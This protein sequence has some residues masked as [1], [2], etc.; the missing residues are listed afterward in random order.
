MKKLFAFVI[1]FMVGCTDAEIASITALGEEA[2][3][4]CFSGGQVSYDGI[5]TGKV[6]TLNGSDGWQFKEKATGD[7]IRI[8]GDCVIRN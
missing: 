4:Q 2:H 7:L 1:L 8:S 6:V 5:S 3:I